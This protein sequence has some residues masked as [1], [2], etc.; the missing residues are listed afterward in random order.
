MAAP[1]DR[2]E[3]VPQSSWGNN[4]IEQLNHLHKVTIARKWQSQ[5]LDLEVSLYSPYTESLQPTAY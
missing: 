2:S 1:W 5:D 3:I 4:G